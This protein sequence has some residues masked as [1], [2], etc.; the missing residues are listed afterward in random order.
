MTIKVLA[1][2]A[3]IM[4]VPEAGNGTFSWTCST[5]DE[6]DAGEPDAAELP[7]GDVVDANE[8]DADPPDAEPMADAAPQCPSDTSGHFIGDSIVVGAFFYGGAAQLTAQGHAVTSQAQ[9]GDTIA[10]QS[11]K[12]MT[13]ARRGDPTLDWVWIQM[14]TNSTSVGAATAASQL[15]A[16]VDDIQAN[17]PTAVIY[18]STVTPQKAYRDATAPG[19]YASYWVPLNDLILGM[20]GV[21]D[22][23]DALND[24]MDDLIPMYDSGDHVHPNSAGHA[25]QG[26]VILSWLDR[27]FTQPCP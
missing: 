7:D 10:S 19:T 17:N 6:P 1:L 21:S 18:L 24:G 9:G 27:D 16:L 23:G 8:P 5:P 25:V 26:T 12:W 13:N 4:A 2:V 11:T 15:D 22:V 20:G 3:T 14:G